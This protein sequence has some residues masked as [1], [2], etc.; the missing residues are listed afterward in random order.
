MGSSG[1]PA[2]FSFHSIFFSVVVFFFS[3]ALSFVS[4]WQTAESFPFRPREE[5]LWRR[6]R[7]SLSESSRKK[8]V[9]LSTADA[10]AACSSRSLSHNGVRL[11]RRRRYRA[12]RRARPSHVKRWQRQRRVG[13]VLFC[14]VGRARYR[15]ADDT[16]A[17]RDSVSSN[18][19]KPQTKKPPPSAR[20]RRPAELKHIAKRRK[21]NQPGFP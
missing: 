2:R 9:T 20:T 5:T 10:N 21:R 11:R 1:F 7:R 19:T 17:D 3:P 12:A 15:P 18:A 13:C 16:R 8:K 4:R 14:S 6:S